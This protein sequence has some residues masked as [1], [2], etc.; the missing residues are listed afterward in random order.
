MVGLS[1]CDADKWSALLNW[2]ASTR[3][4]GPA[5]AVDCGGS[6]VAR[7]IRRVNKSLTEL[8]VVEMVR[9]YEEGRST[10]QIAKATG[11]HW[12]TVQNRLRAVG[13]TMRR[14]IKTPEA[15][16]DE[17]VRL[18]ESGLSMQAVGDQVGVNQQTVCN[19]LHERGVATRSR[20][21]QPLTQVVAAS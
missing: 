5:L 10:R 8:E 18:Y 20:R 11:V 2:R 9:M 4:R 7:E 14:R 16:I 21:A 19:M 12:H 17:I 3:Q 13:V 6:T 15:V 1:T